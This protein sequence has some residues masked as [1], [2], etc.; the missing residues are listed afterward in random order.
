MA[1]QPIKEQTAKMVKVI[2]LVKPDTNAYGFEVYEVDEKS[3]GPVV[4]KCEPD[5][6]A[7]CLNNITKLVREMFGI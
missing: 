1:K 7:I 2:R 5:I 3:L 4:S 6:F